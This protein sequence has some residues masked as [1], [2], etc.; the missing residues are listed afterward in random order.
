MSHVVLVDRENQL[1]K[2]H[3]IAPLLLVLSGIA[4]SL[5]AAPV[6]N[7][8]TPVGLQAGQDVILTVDGTDLLPNPRL[9]A[10]FPIETQEIQANPAANKVT[11]KL[12]IPANVSA[13]LHTIRIASD[14]GSSNYLMIAIDRLPQQAFAEKISALPMAVNGQP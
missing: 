1:M 6:I 2:I 7:K 8:L 13:G 11:M 10:S 3:L 12:K 9:I 4:G 14:R 5:A